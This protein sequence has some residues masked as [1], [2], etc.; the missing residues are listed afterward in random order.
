[1]KEKKWK[2]VVFKS[3]KSLKDRKCL[4]CKTAI[5]KGEQYYPLEN[6]KALCGNPECRIK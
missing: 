3:K 1:M 5:A 6:D 2:V 4:S